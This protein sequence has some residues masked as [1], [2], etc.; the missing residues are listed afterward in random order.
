M[1][2]SFQMNEL[3]FLSFNVEGLESMLL[4]PGFMDLVLQHDICLLTETMRKDNSKLNLDGLWDF[5]QIRPKCKK[6]GRN[7]GGITVL[8]KGTAP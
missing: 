7:S 1:A 4:D 2:S 8:V 6:K 5:S 3:T